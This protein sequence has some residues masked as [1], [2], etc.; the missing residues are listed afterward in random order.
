MSAE[1]LGKK[2]SVMVVFTSRCATLL[3][4]MEVGVSRFLEPCE[5]CKFLFLDREEIQI[6][7]LTSCHHVIGLDA[8]GSPDDIVEFKV[9]DEILRLEA[10][11]TKAKL[12]FFYVERGDDFSQVVRDMAVHLKNVM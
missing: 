4:E 5:G 7:K 2:G 10:L 11:R 9:D 12:V 3:L 8:S 1:V 6:E